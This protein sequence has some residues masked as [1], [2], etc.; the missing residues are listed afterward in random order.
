M[1]MPAVLCP[2]LEGPFVR[3]TRAAAEGKLGHGW[4]VSG[5]YGIGKRNLAYL[6]ATRLLSGKIEG[7]LPEPAGARA[8][9]AAYADLAAS[10]DL[11]PD[12]HR[13]RADEGKRSIAVDQIRAVT[14]DIGLTPHLAGCKLVVIEQAQIMTIEAANA[15]LKSLEEP[16]PNT[17]LFLLAERP[18]RLPA[19]IRSRCQHLR[20]RPP[21]PGTA[22]EWFRADGIDTAGLP[23][24][25]LATAPVAWAERLS[26]SDKTKEINILIE[27]IK[28]ISS[29]SADAHEI[30]R[31]WQK[32]DLDLALDCLSV[33]LRGRIREQ[34][35]PG[36]SNPFTDLTRGMN[37]N[38]RRRVPIDSLFAGLKMV[39]NLRDQLGRGINEELSLTALLL[40]L[41]LP[42]DRRT[43]A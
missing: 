25:R 43:N 28:A 24:E 15:L 17:W 2:W 23:S 18:G 29:N 36:L 16:T 26:D 37:E 11:H 13:V 30:A 22:T 34:L 20:L 39:E 12:L 7:P 4:L 19:T 42:E 8:I 32:G 27:D 1:S 9:A 6:L 5:P 35:I 38:E 10:E 33:S 40:G 21:A 3:L 41:R 31:R 14:A